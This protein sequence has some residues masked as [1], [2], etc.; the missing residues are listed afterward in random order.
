MEH[1]KVVDLSED[2]GCFEVVVSQ[3]NPESDFN[4][5]DWTTEMEQYS[6]K[7]EEATKVMDVLPELRDAF[8]QRKDA[9]MSAGS[10]AGSIPPPRWNPRTRPRASASTKER[11]LRIGKL[12][13]GI[14]RLPCASNQSS[15][16]QLNHQPQTPDRHH[17]DQRFCPFDQKQ[18]RRDHS[19]IYPSTAEYNP[20]NKRLKSKE[21]SGN[22][23][24]APYGSKNDTHR[25]ETHRNHLNRDMFKK[26]QE[27]DA[28]KM[29]LEEKIRRVDDR[30]R[31]LESR[32]NNVVTKL[33]E[34]EISKADLEEKNSKFRQSLD[35]SVERMSNE[36]KEYELFCC[37][38]ASEM[39]VLKAEF[40]NEMMMQIKALNAQ[41][42][43]FEKN[44]KF[45]AEELDD[46][47]E[48][49]ESYRLAKTK[50]LDAREA[51]QYMLQ[52]DVEARLSMCVSGE[53][54]LAEATRDFNVSRA[55]R[56]AEHEELSKQLQQKQDDLNR[57]VDRHKEEMYA[58]TL[59]KS[60]Q[61]GDLESRILEF[62]TVRRS[63][64]SS[65]A[66]Q[67]EALKK[68]QRDL[69]A[70]EADLIRRSRELRVMR[71]ELAGIKRQGHEGSTTSSAKQAP[72]QRVVDVDQKTPKPVDYILIDSDDEDHKSA[73][74]ARTSTAQ[75]QSRKKPDQCTASFGSAPQ[76]RRKPAND[77]YR[78]NYEENYSYSLSEETAFELQE[79]LFREAAE[80][81]RARATF[82]VAS[83]FTSTTA[84]F[85]VSSP[86][87]DIA[88]RHPNHWM[89]KDPYAVLGLPPQ[90]P[91]HLVKSQYR[92]LA[93]TYHPDKSGDS[94][95][96]TKFH[97]IST[98]YHKLVDKVC[99]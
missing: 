32:E 21:F 28:L 38:K 6:A 55:A 1:R 18:T 33:R 24:V 48:R 19:H 25:F 83:A 63:Q 94:N 64:Q 20:R 10:R 95:T 82:P 34:I 52:Q 36:R 91:M 69:D 37:R 92:R 39:E 22:H 46:E 68:L 16:N 40:Q 66:F 49:L 51:A 70:R 59:M 88:D 53:K 9:T 87:L 35:A 44:M 3:A 80:K 65:Q 17:G 67:A 73:E 86:I 41:L 75:A 60:T 98:A 50:E 7:E 77:P 61:E 29:E 74:T 26:R 56:D 23:L 54:K 84:D 42:E 85:A 13:N 71:K 14:K 12:D 5:F 57:K 78:F 90:T 15:T 43:L 2:P 97:A 30:Q 11:R 76:K 93:R 8:L 72:K 96:S 45:R 99:R 89:W 62:D 27:L 4:A 79:R 58:W 81:M 31:S 47:R